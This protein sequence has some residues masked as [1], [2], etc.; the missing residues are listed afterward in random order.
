[1]NVDKVKLL[2]G[3][4]EIMKFTD[5][6]HQS[7]QHVVI[8]GEN[9]KIEAVSYAGYAE[10]FLPIKNFQHPV[11][12]Q[13][14]TALVSEKFCLDPRLLKDIVMTV[15]TKTITL[16]S[17][18][19]A[20]KFMPEPKFHAKQLSVSN[21]FQEIILYPL[22]KF[23]SNSIYG[24][25]KKVGELEKNEIRH[26]ATISQLA[27]DI[28]Y[29]DYVMIDMDNNVMVSSDGKRFHVVRKHFTGKGRLLCTG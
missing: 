24:Q 14:G 7:H 15:D 26:V 8:D 23:P 18:F 1:M 29:H 20:S 3:L 10:I 13:S 4:R 11:A 22:S 12:C 9:Q 6:R 25:I 27:S 17:D 21:C 5:A 19:D 16:R 2:K 28:P